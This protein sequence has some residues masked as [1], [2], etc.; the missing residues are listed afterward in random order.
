MFLAR[1]KEMLHQVHK[2][3]SNYFL[4]IL[5]WYTKNEIT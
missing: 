5:T 3:L 4:E 1:K 2:K